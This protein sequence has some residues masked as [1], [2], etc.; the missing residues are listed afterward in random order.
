M[1]KVSKEGVKSI[2]CN[3]DI[4]IQIEKKTLDIYLHLIET[5]IKPMTLY[6]W[7][8]CD[9]CDKKSR[10]KVQPFHVLPCKQVLRIRKTTGNMKVLAELGRFPFKIYIETQMFKNLKLLLFLE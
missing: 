4:I 6:D 8:S 7:E 10:I 9:D 3:S 1:I 2:V 5:I